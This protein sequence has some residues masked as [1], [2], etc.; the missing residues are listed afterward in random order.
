MSHEAVQRTGDRTEASVL[1]SSAVYRSAAEAGAEDLH[2]TG[3]TAE[4]LDCGRGDEKKTG[5]CEDRMLFGSQSIN[6]SSY[7]KGEEK[8]LKQ[9]P[10]ISDSI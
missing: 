9:Y 7:N 4:G 3:V 2:I 6:P 5:N 10:Q 1:V 8:K